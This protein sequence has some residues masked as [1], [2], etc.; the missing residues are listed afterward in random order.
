MKRDGPL[1]FGGL[2]LAQRRS[3]IVIREDIHLLLIL[4][5][6]SLLLLLGLGFGFQLRL[7]EG[8]A[9][10]FSGV[11]I[12]R[13]LQ[14]GTRS[15]RSCG[16]GGGGSCTRT[17]AAHRARNSVV[18]FHQRRATHVAAQDRRQVDIHRKWHL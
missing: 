18:S 17:S 5:L 16:G 15:S 1:A 9:A 4:L 14:F 13:C 8:L 2:L 6:E 7:R 3:I 11:A 12:E 10:R